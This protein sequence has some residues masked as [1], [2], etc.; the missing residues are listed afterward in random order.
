MY[1][2]GFPKIAYDPVGNDNKEIVTDIL[3]RVAI[4]QSTRDRKAL[5]SEYD[6]FDYE[7]PESVAFEVY[8]QA[9]YHWVIMMFNKYYDR[10]Y[11]WP[12]STRNLQKYVEDKYSNPNGIH[13]Y[14]TSQSSGDTTVKIKVELADVPTATS[15][16]NYEYEQ[17]LNDVRKQIKILVPGYLP[18]F[19]KEFKSLLIKQE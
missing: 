7:T 17:N 9:E 11:E 19:L 3:T 5:F 14:E 10:Y 12:M 15:I 13:H 16:T 18:S 6:V 8:G 4:R 1:F 2:K